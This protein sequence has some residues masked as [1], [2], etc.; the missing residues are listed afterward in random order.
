MSDKKSPEQNQFQLT[1]ICVIATLLV[2][3]ICWSKYGHKAIHFWHQYR[4]RFEILAVIIGLWAVVMIVLKLWEK[5]VDWRSERA[6]TE[7]EEHA[8]YLGKDEHGQRL[9]LHEEYRTGHAQVIGTTNAGKTESIVLPWVIQ[10]IQNGSGIIII[11]GKSDRAFLDKLY[12]YA[13]DANRSSDFRLFSLAETQLSST[14]N[15]LFG[16]SPQEVTERVFSSFEFDN[17]YFRDVQFKIFLAIVTLIHEQKKTPTFKLVHRLLTDMEELSKWLEDCEDDDLERQL[18]M[19]HDEDKEM[20][21]QRIS[22][23]D[24]KLSHFSL[25]ELSTLFNAEHPQIDM[26]RALRENLIC[27][28]QLPTMYYGEL[29][30]A[31][32]KLVLQSLQSEIA[33]RHLGLSKKPRFFC[34]YLDDFQDYIYE[35]FGALLNKSR[36]ANVGIVFSHQALGDLKKVSDSFANVVITNTNIKVVMRSNDPE[37]CD[38][39]AKTFGTR[40]SEKVT[41]RRVSGALGDTNT[42]EGSVRE[43]EEYVYHPNTIRRLERGQGVIAIPH[44][45]G[46]KMSLVKF[47]RRPDITLLT[48]PEVPKPTSGNSSKTKETKES[49][50]PPGKI[51]DEHIKKDETERNSNESCN[52]S[53]TS[54]PDSNS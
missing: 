40:K 13:A 9:Y 41:E 31:T 6:V 19:F 3:G 21:N 34:C 10:D 52:T 7:P 4:T 30:K 38:Y 39:L 35:G 42:G 15:P 49:T 45:R 29:S 50:R 26:N 32:G 8:I 44:P 16:G 23:L 2:L 36:S 17:Q 1:G 47:K 48:I 51:K 12:A 5:Y 33:K 53:G 46:V 20:R 28:F 14:I 22:G 37:T 27:Y 43:V 54:I 18:R 24:A 11:D 25:G